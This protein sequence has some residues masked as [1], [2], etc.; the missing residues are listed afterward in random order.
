MKQQNV[1]SFVD[2]YQHYKAEQCVHISQHLTL[3][4]SHCYHSRHKV[5]RCEV[6]C[7]SLLPRQMARYLMHPQCYHMAELSCG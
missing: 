3:I 1:T 6:Q 5:L 7:H 2:T 4:D